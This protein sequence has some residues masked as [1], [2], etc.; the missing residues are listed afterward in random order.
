MTH[1]FGAM[2]RSLVVPLAILLAAYFAVP[3]LQQTPEK[4]HFL[5]QYL[6]HATAALVLLLALL[7]NQARIFCIALLLVIGHWLLM[8]LQAAGAGGG[9]LD[10]RGLVSAY[11]V[12][13]PLN[14]VFFSL[15]RERGLFNSHGAGLIGLV[16]VQA[17]LVAWIIRDQPL[18]LLAVIT[19]AW[20]PLE[21]SLP[22]PQAGM[23][24]FFFAVLVL[25]WRLW[26]QPHFLN[27]CLLLLVPALA[28]GVYWIEVA[29][30][31]QAILSAAALMLSLGVILDMQR[32]AYRDDLTGLPARRAL[33]FRLAAPGR[34][35]TIAMLDVDHFKKF[36]DTHGHD[37][38][39]DVLRMVASQLQRVG[40]GGRVFRYGGEEFTIVF[41]RRD[42]EHARPYLEAIRQSIAD[43]PLVVR[44]KQRPSDGKAGR[45]Q[46][47]GQ[48]KRHKSTRVT[49]SIGVAERNGEL[50][51]PEAVLKAAD[52]ALYR[53]KRG[54]RNRV[55]D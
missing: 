40:G 9:G 20:L 27:A 31:P 17:V 39:D 52:K 16:L 18:E 48:K 26:R 1:S 44:G 53:A 32:I 5:V 43:Y 42:I 34:R 50:R 14:L 4:L 38:G 21:V 46:R 10:S 45:K 12:V 3:P 13:L 33:N 49:I 25:G 54:G 24:V 2:A 28:G 41:P 6:P 19:H 55:S 7:F 37:V 35:Y 30:A 36:N 23:L 8:Q 15:L 11:S 22:V 51:H 29:V 47:G